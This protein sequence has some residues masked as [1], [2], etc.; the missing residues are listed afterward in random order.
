MPTIGRGGAAGTITTPVPGG[1]YTDTWHAPRDGGRRR[2]MGTDIF[3]P[4]GSAVVAPVAGRIDPARYGNDG[5]NGG[6]RLW[7]FGDD[8]RSYYFAH[9]DGID[10]RRG[11]RVSSGQRIG[12]VGNTG[13]ATTTPPHLHFEVHVGGRAVNPYPILQ[14]AGPGDPATIATAASWSAPGGIANPANVAR[15]VAPLVGL[16]WLTSTEGRR[17]ATYIAAGAAVGTVAL[18]YIFRDDLPELAALVATKG[19]L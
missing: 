4:R 16:G 7:L 2:H 6:I 8:S 3:A 9:L 18:V 5:G 12:R 14:G 1:T 15:A 17:R 19:K 10:V 11:A 13:N